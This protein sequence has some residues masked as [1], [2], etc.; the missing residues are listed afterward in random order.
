MIPDSYPEEHQASNHEDVVRLYLLPEFE[1]ANLPATPFCKST[2]GSVQ[3][4]GPMQATF[5]ITIGSMTIRINNEAD[6]VLLSYRK[7]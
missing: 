5:E 6:S 7:W 2:V 1:E 4:A 3:N